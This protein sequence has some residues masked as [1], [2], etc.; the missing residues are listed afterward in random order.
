MQITSF[1]MW[2]TMWLL[3]PRHYLTLLIIII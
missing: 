2:P 1:I 3:Q